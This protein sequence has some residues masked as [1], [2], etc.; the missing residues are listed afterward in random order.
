M[1]A[2]AATVIG[3]IVATPIIWYLRG[4]RN[5]VRE[6]LERSEEAYERSL[7]N[8]AVLEDHDMIDE[9]DVEHI[10]HKNERRRA[11]P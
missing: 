9:S 7:D 4:I 6:F 3:T 10:D 1:I 11:N 2:V 8:A 5:D